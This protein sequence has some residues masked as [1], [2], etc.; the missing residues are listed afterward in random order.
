M[1]KTEAGLFWIVV[2]PYWSL[3][4]LDYRM[5]ETFPTPR[6]YA[7]DHAVIVEYEAVIDPMCHASQLC[8]IS[9]VDIV[10]RFLGIRSY[11]V[12]TPYQLYRRLHG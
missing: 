12:W 7:G 2:N 8:I 5:V 1:T 4:D 10:K 6:D 9:C 11:K 3:I